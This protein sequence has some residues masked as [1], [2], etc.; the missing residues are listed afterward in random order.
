MKTKLSDKSITWA[1]D[2]EPNTLEQIQEVEKLPMLFQH[3]AYMPDVHFGFGVPIG[4]VIALKD[5]ICPVQIGVDIG[6]GMGAVKFGVKADV[7][8]RED[9]T[10]I[11][12]EIKKVV[13]VG[14]AHHQKVPGKWNKLELFMGGPG[15]HSLLAPILDRNENLKSTP[16][17]EEYIMK[18]LGTLGGGNHFIELQ[19]DEGGYLWAML[20]SGSRNM[21]KLVC[22]YYVKLTEEEHKKWYIP[23]PKDLAWIPVDT[24]LGQ[25]YLTAMNFC[26]E[27]AMESRKRMMDK[28]IGV[29]MQ[30]LETKADLTDIQVDEEI[31]IHHNYVALEK[32]FNHNVWVHRKGAT[33]AKKGQKGIIPGNMSKDS[34]SFIVE[35]LGNPVSFM[36]C[37]HGAGRKMGRMDASRRVTEEEANKAMG[38]VVFDGWRTIKKGKLKGK[39]DLGECHQAYKDIY[40]IIANQVDLVKPIVTLKALATLK[41]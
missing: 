11:C 12:D 21:G 10:K 20:H 16:E 13:P 3:A 4:S 39:V 24:K 38:D 17:V 36:S 25:D 34:A 2:I 28:V 35:G 23:H 41:G 1:T 5:C 8:N 22:D 37:S 15:R 33:S 14:F 26:L 18:Q 30:A 29:V 27:F 9:L 31:N 7:F 6:C 40:E 32:H 19:V